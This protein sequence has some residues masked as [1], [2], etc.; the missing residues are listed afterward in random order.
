MHIEWQGLEDVIAA[1]LAG[2]VGGAITGAIVAHFLAKRRDATSRKH[3]LDD[4]RKARRTSFLS[5]LRVWEG[6][7]DRNISIIHPANVIINIAGQFDAKRAE[8]IGKAAELRPDY[9]GE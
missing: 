2:S 1:L 3:I 9:E 6:E 4:L 5:S 8:F 7:V